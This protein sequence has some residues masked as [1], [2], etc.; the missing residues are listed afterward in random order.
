M[1]R[2]RLPVLLLGLLGALAA[3]GPFSIDLYL[4]AFPAIQADL[5]TTPDRVQATL[6]AYFAGLAIGQ[7]ALGPI[8]DRFGRKAPLIVGLVLYVAASIGCAFAP[9]IEVLL[10]LRFVQAVGACSGIVASRA[11]LRDLYPPRDM[12]RALSFIMLLMGIA[13][14]VAPLLG[15]GIQVLVGWHALFLFLAV[16]GAVVLLG[17]GLG[18][19]ETMTT[20][21][22]PLRPGII[23]RN[24]LGLFA[25]RR[26]LVFALA[27]SAAQAGMFVYISSSSFVFMDV[28]GLGPIQYAMLFGFN[29]MGLITASQVNERWLRRSTPERIVGIILVVFV[30]SALAMLLAV[31]TGLGGVIGVA[32]PLWVTVA[33]LGFCFPNT[34]AAAMGPVGNRAGVAS[35][36][37]GTMQYGVAG[38]ASLVAGLLYDGTAW[39]MAALILGCGVVALG[40]LVVSGELRRAAVSFTP[41]TTPS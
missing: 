32:I 27:G 37:L 8:V 25:E 36:L 29:A 18:L 23:A 11:V 28:Y 16:Y 4:P 30:L 41:G 31:V 22:T 2:T 35:A 7:I 39:P 10:G 33:C 24:Y 21:P 1:S 3:I 17:T 15:S 19:P 20:E 12:A 26:Y 13:P 14:I 9:S 5:G 40:L 38:L 6:S 34:T